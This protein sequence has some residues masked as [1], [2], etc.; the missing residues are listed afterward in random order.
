MN[1]VSTHQGTDTPNIMIAII[2]TLSLVVAARR[3]CGPRA[4]TQRFSNGENVVSATCGSRGSPF[5]LPARLADGLGLGSDL[6]H[7]YPRPCAPSPI[8]SRNLVPP[9]WPSG[10]KANLGCYCTDNPSIA[11]RS[12]N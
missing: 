3:G 2:T 11:R 8:A 7:G 10:R 4:R 12:R 6:G 1:M 9:H 5:H